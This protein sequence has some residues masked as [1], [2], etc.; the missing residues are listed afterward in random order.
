MRKSEAVRLE[1]PRKW[2]SAIVSE[3]KMV[4]R[5]PAPPP[6]YV[7]S[8]LDVDGVEWFVDGRTRLWSDGNSEPTSWDWLLWNRGPLTAGRMAP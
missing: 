7:L 8:V 4:W 1:R 3:L 6:D 5:I 2:R